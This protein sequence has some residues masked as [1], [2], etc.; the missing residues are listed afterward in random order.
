MLQ[1]GAVGEQF[2]AFGDDLTEGRKIERID[3]LQ[4]GRDLPAEE[5]ADDADDAEPIGKNLAGT[6]PQPVGGQRIRFVDGD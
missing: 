2:V 1:D 6:L 4:P 3:D 5:K